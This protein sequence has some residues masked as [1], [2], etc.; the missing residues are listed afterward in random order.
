MS[1]TATKQALVECTECGGDG[2]VETI[3]GEPDIEDGEEPTMADF[4]TIQIECDRCGGRG[5]EYDGLGCPR[6]GAPEGAL[7][8]SLMPAGDYKQNCRECVWW[9]YVG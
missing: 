8:S 9:T 4:D 6:C 5:T 2:T 1:E 7:S 3:G